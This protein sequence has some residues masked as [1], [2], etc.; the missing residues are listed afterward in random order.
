MRTVTL[1]NSTV[2]DNTAVGGG[3]G[4]VENNNQGVLMLNNCTIGAAMG[5]PGLEPGT[6]RL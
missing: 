5:P 4:V 3:G 2:T 1:D 6:Y